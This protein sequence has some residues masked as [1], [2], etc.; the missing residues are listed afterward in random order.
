MS[1]VIG[2]IGAL[3]LVGGGVLLVVFGLRQSQRTGVDR[4]RAAIDEG[5]DSTSRE[6]SVLAQAWT[7]M[8]AA[9]ERAGKGGSMLTWLGVALERSGWPLRPA[10]FSIAVAGAT[11]LAG[12]V[13]SVALGG[14]GAGL[15]AAVVVAVV[16]VLL[17]QRKSR[18]L[19]ERA[20]RQLPDVLGQLAA[21]LRSGHSLNQAVEAAGEQADAPLGPQLTRVI[22][23]TRVGRSLDDALAAMAERVGSTDLRW[24]VRA[25]MIQSRTGGKLSDVLDVLAE[26][27]RDR[28]EVRREVRALTAD[29]RISA[30]VLGSLP[31]VVLGALLVTSRDYLTPLVTEPLGFAMIGGAAVLMAIG[32]VWIR[33]IVRVEV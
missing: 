24:T 31:F 13:G 26:F 32:M 25:M 5:I 9:T 15:L 4:L 7:A 18:V 20:D 33:K 12:I 21:S 3:L 17:L 28:E 2:I 30:L 8:T 1:P 16:P 23:E 14:V 22:A 6:V 10:E 27:M 29:G 11:I 19:G